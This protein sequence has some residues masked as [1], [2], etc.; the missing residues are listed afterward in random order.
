MS[1]GVPP[2]ANV[3]LCYSDGRQVLADSLYTGLEDN[4]RRWLVVIVPMY[5]VGGLEAV[6]LSIEVP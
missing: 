3:V 1:D 2:P 4:G 5:E 6:T